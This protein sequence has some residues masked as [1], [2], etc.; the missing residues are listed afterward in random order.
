M[1]ELAT[2]ARPYAQAVFSLAQAT[3]SL[4]EWSEMLGLLA[5]VVKN[6]T[7]R[8]LLRSKRIERQQLT[9]LLLAISD[10]HLRDEGKSL[11]KILADNHKLILLPE[12]SRQYEQLKAAQEGYISVEVVS[13]YA[14]KAQ[15]KQQI[16]DAL[17]KRLGKEVK[18]ETQIDRRLLGGWLIRI[19]D[20]VLDLTV[21]GRLQQIGAELRR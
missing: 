6:E 9:G 11:L 12:I 16:T 15:H 17:Q 20:Q 2:I 7:I 14:V 18:I 19:G 10:G 13:T 1:A 5:E 21:R 4:A 3:S 8:D